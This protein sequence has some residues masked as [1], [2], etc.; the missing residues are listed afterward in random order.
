MQGCDRERDLH[1]VQS[2]DPSPQI[3]VSVLNL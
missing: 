1:P 3:S 2:E